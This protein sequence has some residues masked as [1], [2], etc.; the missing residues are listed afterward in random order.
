MYDYII[1]GAGFSGSVLAERIASQLDKKVLIVEKRNHIGGNAYDYFDD[2]GVLVHKYG[3][4]IFHTNSKKVIDYLSHFTA[5]RPYFHKVLAVIEGK[6]VPVPF[7]L[8]SIYA[9]FPP[10]FSA[11]IEDELLRNFE[12]GQKIPILKLREQASDNL[13]WLADYIYE[14]VFKGYTIKQWGMKP[15]ELDSSVTARIPVVLSRDDRYFQDIYQLMPRDGYTELFKRILNNK[16][17]NILLQT[18][19]QDVL[20]VIP[21][22]NVVFTGPIDEYYEYCF[23]ELPYRS[24]EFE[25]KSVNSE[26]YQEVGQMN[27]PN[28]NDFTR[29]SEFKHLTGQ[30]TA[31]TSVAYEYP[32]SY[33][34]GN[35][36]TPYYPIPRSENNQLYER[37][38]SLQKGNIIF[39]G[40]LADYKY[41]NMDQVIA[42]ALTVFEKE[43]ASK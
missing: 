3:P 32:R 22:K 10:N 30:L 42:R 34:S 7:N 29:I 31:C 35:N 12:Y 1:V 13:K 16:N 20:E 41:Y 5:W 24:L 9:L 6:K 36:S 21:T 4:H 17:I 14:N 11:R 43:I 39:C 19:Y 37:Y 23:G 15:E 8:N 38:N 18:R 26:F 33:S 25:F 40:R 27:F 2:N 28:N